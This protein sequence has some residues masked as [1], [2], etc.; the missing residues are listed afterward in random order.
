MEHVE[1]KP[2]NS[3]PEKYRNFFLKKKGHSALSYQP[4][5]LLY[6]HISS[7]QSSVSG[8]ITPE[9]IVDWQ[10]LFDRITALM[11]AA[12]GVNFG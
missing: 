4:F 7:I 6:Q 12:D 2:R 10:R 9:L 8:F 11:L 3:V 5:S 1:G